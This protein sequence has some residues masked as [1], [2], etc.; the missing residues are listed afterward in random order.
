MVQF[1]GGVKERWHILYEDRHLLGIY[2]PAGITVQG[3]HRG[4]EGL[5]FG[6]REYLR[7]RYGGNPFLAPVH[8]LDK[9]TSGVVLFAR[10]EKAA[11]RLAEA[12]REGEISKVYVA[13]VEGRF[14]LSAGRLRHFL[15]W[16]EGARRVRVS[17]QPFPGAR[18]AVTEFRVFFRSRELTGILLFPETGRKHQLRA[19]LAREGHPVVGDRRYGSRRRASRKGAILLH[20]LALALEHPVKREPLFLFAPLPDYFPIAGPE[21]GEIARLLGMDREPNRI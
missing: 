9:V 17:D 11:R 6:V 20:A 7:R 12:F 16:E 13:V 14:P 15:R 21:P 18:E 8:R 3:V 5:L 19:Q 2:K 1:G 4:E 10:S